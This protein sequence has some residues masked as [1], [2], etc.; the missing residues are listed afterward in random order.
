LTHAVD[1]PP[2]SVT[3]YRLPV[4][5]CPIPSDVSG[6]IMRNGHSQGYQSPLFFLSIRNKHCKRTLVHRISF[7][8]ERLRCI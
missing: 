4:D 6:N 2:M 1:R 3:P 7:G 8:K 5:E